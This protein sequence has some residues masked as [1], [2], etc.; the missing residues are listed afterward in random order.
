MAG[1]MKGAGF[2]WTEPANCRS[3]GLQP[4]FLLLSS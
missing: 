3:T 2:S 1:L 4:R